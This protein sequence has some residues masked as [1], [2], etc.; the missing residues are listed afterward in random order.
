[1][2]VACL[3]LILA[4]FC[5]GCAT[6]AH[7]EVLIELLVTELQYSLDNK[8]M[9]EMQGDGYKKFPYD[10]VEKEQIRK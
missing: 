6:I 3:A 10:T 9:E 7:D 1:M 2:R 4:C 5:G 8:T